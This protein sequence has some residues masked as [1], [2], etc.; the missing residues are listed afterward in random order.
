ME[1]KKK[2]GGEVVEKT[3]AY[4]QMLIHAER[5]GRERKHINKN[6]HEE[7]TFNPLQCK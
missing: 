3:N 6:L 5:I 4:H 7:F 2:A 1:E